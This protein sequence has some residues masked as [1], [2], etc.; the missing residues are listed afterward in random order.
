MKVSIHGFAG[1]K[2]VAEIIG[3]LSPEE[4]QDIT[5]N[6]KA[7]LLAVHPKA[8]ERKVTRAF[9]VIDCEEKQVA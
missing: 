6:P 4:L 7:Y 3:D 8:K 5:A 2:H 9:A 1:M